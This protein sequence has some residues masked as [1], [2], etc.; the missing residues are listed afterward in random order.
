[1]NLEH[2]NVQK[3]SENIFHEKYS[4]T[5]KWEWQTLKI[6]YIVNSSMDFSKIWH[7]VRA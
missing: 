4:H 1:M 3:L 6:T 2:N 5:P 7:E